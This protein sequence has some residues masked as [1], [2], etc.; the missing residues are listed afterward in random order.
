[1]LEALAYSRAQVGEERAQ[2]DG[3]GQQLLLAVRTRHLDVPA[4]VHKLQGREGPGALRMSGTPSSSTCTGSRLDCQPAGRVRRPQACAS[5]SASARV[6]PSSAGK[7]AGRR[8]RFGDF[9]SRCTM[10]LVRLCRYLPGTP[11]RGERDTCLLHKSNMTRHA[12]SH[13][14][15]LL[16][17]PPALQP[18]TPRLFPMS[19]AAACTQ[20]LR[21]P[22]TACP[23]QRPAPRT[24]AAARS[25]RRPAQGRA[26]R[27]TAH[28]HA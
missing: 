8:T 19:W 6:R 21:E 22:L 17:H 20:R 14:T 15:G 7:E 28:L 2:L 25:A 3:S 10:G 23:A 12:P 5:G 11:R 16:C 27:G 9:K 18:A 1:M 4:L 13:K 26:A 24:G